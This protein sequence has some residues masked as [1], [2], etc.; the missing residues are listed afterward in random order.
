MA[1]KIDQRGY[2]ATKISQSAI[3]NDAI[4]P[5][6]AVKK[7]EEIPKTTSTR[8]SIGGGRK[9]TEKAATGGEIIKNAVYS[10]LSQFNKGLASTLDFLLPTEFLGE[11][12]PVSRLNDYYSGQADKYSAALEESTAD[13]SKAVQL[14]AQTLANATAAVPNAALAV[15]SGGSSAAAQGTTSALTAA[16]SAAQS[17]GI[18]STAANAAQGMVKNPL[19]WLSVGQTLGNNYENAKA[20]GANE[21]QAIGSAYTSSMLNAAI[22]AGGGLET[23]PNVLKRGSVGPVTAWAR[24]ALTEGFEEPVQSAV[25]SLSE[26]L[27]YDRDKPL[28][29]RTDPTAVINPKRM[30]QEFAMGTAVGGILGTGQLAGSNLA[31]TASMK[32]ARRG[33][34][35]GFV[36]E[37]DGLIRQKKLDALMAE[38][39]K[40]VGNTMPSQETAPDGAKT[41]EFSGQAEYAEWLAS[42]GAEGSELDTLEKYNEAKYNN[43]S[44]Y[45]LLSGY[46]RAVE[47]GDLSPLIG[48]K[49]YSQTD[50]LL[51]ESVIGTVT[52]TGVKIESYA[53]HFIDRVIGQTST[54][55]PGM[56]CGVSVEDIVDAL[57]NPISKDP[58]CNMEN[59]DI[60]QRIYGAT[61]SVVISIRDKKLI[62][63]N[64]TGGNLK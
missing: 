1:H 37:M 2:T 52:P 35:S 19:F 58:I 57:V 7:K 29:S 36:R 13:R 45:Q 17:S 61:A 41:H 26:K 6:E 11:Y 44:E 56:R 22:E 54:T 47:K 59:G 32:L 23:L 38:Y 21:W 42:I 62:S 5:T 24:S 15:L 51:K 18:L 53:T 43:T 31:D 55:H 34:Y 30:G 49:E 27:F 14:G 4:E 20:K 50:R 63:A 39:E 48:Y 40:H 60:R 64:P 10:G 46:E 9:P 16:S 25:S 28:F 3:L 8:T 12:D 33:D